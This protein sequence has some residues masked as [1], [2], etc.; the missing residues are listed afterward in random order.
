MSN[1]GALENQARALAASGNLVD[2]ESL[3][4]SALPPRRMRIIAAAAQEFLDRKSYDQAVAWMQRAVDEP[5]ARPI[6]LLELGRYAEERHTE[7]RVLALAV[8]L[9]ERALAERDPSDRGLLVPILANLAEAR[10]RSGDHTHAMELLQQAIDE[11]DRSAAA[12]AHGGVFWRWMLRTFRADLA[13]GS[14]SRQEAAAAY[15]EALRDPLAM[16]EFERFAE[17][18]R[19][20]GLDTAELL[21]ERDQRDADLTRLSRATRVQMVT[22]DGKALW[23]SFWEGRAG[24]PGIVLIPMAGY[25]RHIWR[26]W[27]TQL[28]TEGWW[29]LALDARGQGLSIG[30]GLEMQVT[31]HD[32]LA[33]LAFLSKRAGTTAPVAIMGASYGGAVAL[34]GA[35]DAGGG[36]KALVLLSPGGLRV[37]ERALAAVSRCRLPSLLVTSVDD[38]TFTDWNLEMYDHAPR[39][40][41]ELRVLPEPGHGTALLETRPALW[42]ELRSWL[43]RHLTSPS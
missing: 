16:V 35:S 6:E 2:L 39:G 42:A 12:G 31:P 28:S 15:A 38:G 29:V 1:V 36:V 33:A 17:R 24:A 40:F 18:C 43:E 7:P 22:A 19:Q 34:L 26:P 41:W 13:W 10:G 3:L 9:L 27:A 8:R 25:S 5:E 14:G 32:G 37:K 4:T 11:A 21:R 30:P 23:G 20:A